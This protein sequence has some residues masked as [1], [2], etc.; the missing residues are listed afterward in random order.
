MMKSGERRSQGLWRFDE[1]LTS[2]GQAGLTLKQTFLAGP[3]NVHR[4]MGGVAAYLLIGVTWAFWL[5]AADGRDPR[6][7]P[8][9]VVLCWYLYR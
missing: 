7:H 2:S 8:L 3:V 4:V 1:T 6:R 9:P 5:Q